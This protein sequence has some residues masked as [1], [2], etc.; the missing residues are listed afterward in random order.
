MDP[1]PDPDL[2]FR[3]DPDQDPHE[4]DADPKHCLHVPNQV[5]TVPH[6]YRLIWKRYR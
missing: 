6:V 2:V 5:D 4:T 1:D 3:M